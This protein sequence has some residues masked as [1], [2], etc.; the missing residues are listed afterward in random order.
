MAEVG[1]T[2]SSNCLKMVKVSQE[3]LSQNLESQARGR[4]KGREKNMWPISLLMLTHLA[5]ENWPQEF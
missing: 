1:S 2:C 3:T 5:D 4:E